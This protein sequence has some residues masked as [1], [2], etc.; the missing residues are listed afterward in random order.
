MGRRGEE[1]LGSGFGL[2]PEQKVSF[3]VV[4]AIALTVTY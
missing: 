4:E 2:I 3:R 1:C